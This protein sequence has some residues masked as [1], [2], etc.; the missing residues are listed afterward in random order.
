MSDIRDVLRTRT[1]GLAASL[2]N[3]DEF[4]LAST[5]GTVK[6][7]RAVRAAVVS[8]AAAVAVVAVGA[9]AWAGYSA[10][11]VGPATSPSPSATPS[12]SASE[13]P[14]STPSPSVTPT[15]DREIVSG[16]DVEI[17]ERLENPTTGEHWHEPQ[18]IENLQL[19]DNADGED[20]NNYFAVGT[21]GKATIIVS[22]ASEFIVYGNGFPVGLMYESDDD[23]LR[24]IACPSAR[25][26][27]DCIDADL[28]PESVAIDT[29]THYDSLT[30][31]ATISPVAGWNLHRTIPD[32]SYVL[33]S[34]YFGSANTFPGNVSE[35]N[36]ISTF[37]YEDRIEL[38]S[39][40]ESTL[41]EYRVRG[42]VPGTTASRYVIETPFGSVIWLGEGNGNSWE[43]SPVNG[44]WYSA[45]AVTWDDGKNTF[46]KSPEGASSFEKPRPVP[47]AELCF[48]PDEVTVDA[49]DPE[50]WVA[51]GDHT[52][53]PRVYLPVEGGNDQSKATWKWLS[54]NS[55]GSEG[56]EADVYPY[57]S[58][59]EF[60]AD[61]S[62]FAWQ[63]PDGQWVLA[64]NSYA[65]QRVY[66]CA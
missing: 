13:G 26:S 43:P 59:K 38:A 28:V 50:Q 54:E 20:L 48:A 39:L 57:S 16:A 33:G 61:R 55:F 42:M 19:E 18:P 60:L 24:F 25:D 2:R 53:G 52:E 3:T 41:A 36:D 40:G 64:I 27:D 35:T 58:Y 15:P 62:V 4:D 11:T 34:S 5:R 44:E 17:L 45:G 10:L 56:D 9:G 12:G 66:E 29:T 37:G 14:S 32:G 7:K 46:T 1:S 23:G 22:T 8:T 21:H 30:Y 65:G 51:A 47:A 63:R 31:P 6:R 49:L